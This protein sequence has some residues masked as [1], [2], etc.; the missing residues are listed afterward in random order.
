M[1]TID[2]GVRRVLVGREVGAASGG[3]PAGSL[4]LRATFLPAYLAILLATG[5]RSVYLAWLGNGVLFWAVAL[6]GLYLQAVAATAIYLALRTVVVSLRDATWIVG[7]S[8]ALP[9]VRSN[10]EGSVRTVL[11]RPP[12]TGRNA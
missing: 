6:V 12:V 7:V 3:L 10:C 1:A 5:V 11:W 2:S 8:T 4:L 9:T